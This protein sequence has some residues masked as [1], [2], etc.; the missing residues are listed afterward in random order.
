M[1]S[2]EGENL[3]RVQGLG[4]LCILRKTKKQTILR[5]AEVTDDLPLRGHAHGIRTFLNKNHFRFT[6]GKVIVILWA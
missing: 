3:E 1:P 2:R 4:Q 5:A 6:I